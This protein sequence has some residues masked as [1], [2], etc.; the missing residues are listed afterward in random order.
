MAGSSWP[1]ASGDAGP[2]RR[3]RGRGGRV[4]APALRRRPGGRRPAVFV[5]HARAHRRRPP[6]VDPAARP[7][8]SREA[9]SRTARPGREDG[10]RHRPLQAGRRPP[11]REVTT[12]KPIESAVRPS[13][14]ATEGPHSRAAGPAAAVTLLRSAGDRWRSVVGAR[15]S[16]SCGGAMLRRRGW[17]ART[18]RHRGLS[19]HQRSGRSEL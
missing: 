3:R 2:G 5:P 17:P 9:A 4:L 6:G 11:T 13:G 18:A 15:R 1:P 10:C 7:C 16:P 8:A 12:S 19:R 14:R